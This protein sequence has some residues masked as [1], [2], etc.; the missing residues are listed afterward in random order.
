MSDQHHGLGLRSL[1]ALS[2]SQQV[3]AGV[4]VLALG[5]SVGLALWSRH[6]H[7]NWGALATVLIGLPVAVLAAIDI[8]R[9]ARESR[10]QL[11]EERWLREECLRAIEHASNRTRNVAIGQLHSRGMARSGF[12]DRAVSDV[13]RWFTRLEELTAHADSATLRQILFMV[14]PAPP[15]PATSDEAMR[16]SDMQALRDL[17]RRG[18]IVLSNEVKAREPGIINP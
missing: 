7:T 10:R 1:P 4:V 8:E 15:M 5:L 18:N 12:Y 6:H 17:V 16:E 2:R 14:E 13:L 3:V 9:R 11:A